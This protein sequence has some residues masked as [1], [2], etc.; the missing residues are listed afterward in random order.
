[1][2][3]IPMDEKDAEEKVEMSAKAL[4]SSLD[5]IRYQFLDRARKS[6]ELTIPTLVPPPGHGSQT[7][8]YTPFQGVGARG[9]NNLASKLLLTLFPPNSPFFRF[10]IDPF[11]L[12]KLGGPNP[13]QLKSE[14]EKA[15]AEMERAVQREVETSSIRVTAYEALRQLIVA[16][17]V[18]IY[19]PKVGNLRMFRMDTYCVKRDPS[20]NVLQIVIC[21]KIAPSALPPEVKAVYNSDETN[22][23]D[24]DATSEQNA[25]VELYTIINRED[26]MERWHIQQ[27]VVDT[28]IPESEGFFPLDKCP[29]LALR[30][31]RVD[32]EDYGRGY[33]EEYIGDLISLEALSQAIV[34][35]SAAAARILFLVNPNGTT[36]AKV[37]AESPNGAIVSGNAAD[38]SVLQLQKSADFSI[39]KATMMTIE[40]RLAFAFLLNSSIQRQAE[41]VT[42]AEIRFMAQ[43]LESSIGG[44][45]SILSQEFQLPLVE[46]LV[47]RMGA[48]RR[49]P[50]LPKKI[51]KPVIV[52]GI[53]ALGRGNDLNKL[54]LFVAGVGQSLGP[55]AVAQFI[56]I[57]E[58]LNRRATAIGIDV[59]G[60]VKTQEQI[61]AET[62][63]AQMMKMTSDLGPSGIKSVT[64]LAMAA[65]PSNQQQQ[66]PPQQ[67]QQQ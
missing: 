59:E 67:Q 46:L 42:A 3:L 54:D 2:A 66:Q 30:F 48:T 57:G 32:G 41:R 43:E 36:R 45:Y 33:V 7:K 65:H 40:E 35:G 55:Q 24:Y 18:L 22:D 29:Y 6:S 47:D 38:V 28:L 60:L 25:T 14:M 53:E 4:Y 50:K 49:L 5:S 37:I 10:V 58:Y 9:V 23:S 39:A 51:V 62:Q 31:N 8:Y 16:G 27:Q 12:K 52:T 34:E 21:E 20:G 44:T 15:L 13:E 26:D 1:M 63:Q 19:M 61:A 56:N 17:N 64:D 11:V